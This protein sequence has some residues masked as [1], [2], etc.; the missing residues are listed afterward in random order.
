M[1]VPVRVRWATLFGIQGATELVEFIGIEPPVIGLKQ[2]AD[3][4]FVDLHL[5]PAGD[6]S[7][8]VAPCR[9]LLPKGI[10]PRLS[11]GPH[12]R[13]PIEPAQAKDAL[14]VLLAL[15]E[16]GLRQPL[17]F[18]PR[19]GWKYYSAKTPERGIEEARRQWQG[20]DRHWGEGGE[21][22]WELALRARDPFGDHGALR[23]FIRNTGAVFAAVDSGIALAPEL[24]EDAIT[25][26]TLARDDDE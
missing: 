23:E 18:A 4:R 2:A 14:R 19:S 26:A 20:G 22:A 21:P 9:L 8:H 7:R 5:Q 16:N 1:Q 12:L 25:R 10:P 3:S 15:R 24:D 11:L 17:S 13:A 6:N